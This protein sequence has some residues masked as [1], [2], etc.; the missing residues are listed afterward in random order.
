MF[1]VPASKDPQIEVSAYSKMFKKSFS[2]QA[3]LP[4]VS[5]EPGHKLKDVKLSKPAKKVKEVK[6]DETQKK[7]DIFFK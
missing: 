7:L 1:E 3:S 2:S 5:S 4:R 6:I